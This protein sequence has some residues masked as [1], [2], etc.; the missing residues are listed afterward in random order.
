MMSLLLKDAI[1]ITGDEK[2]TVINEGYIGIKGSLIDYV[3]SKCEKID[4]RYDRILDL[5]NK[6]IMPGFVNAHNHSAMTIF[7]NYADDLALMDWLFNKIFPLEEKLTA[8][9]VYWASMLAVLEMIRTGTTAFCDM[10]MFME[11]TA[12]V[13]SESGIKAALGRGL[14]GDIGAKDSYRLKESIE[15]YKSYHHSNNGRIRVNLAPHSVY[16]CTLSYLEEIAKV[17]I[18]L[19]C[20]VQIH[21]SETDDEVSKSILEHK[22]TPVKVADEVGLLSN[23]TIA[24]HCVAVNDDD[25]EILMKKKVNVVHNPS[26]NMKLGSGIAPIKGMLDKGIN[27]AIGTDGASSNNGLDMLREMRNASYLQKVLL[28]D[29]T[30][31]NVDQAIKMS[32]SN[33]A[34]ALGFKNT[35]KIA[36]GNAA[37]IIIINTDKP[38][39]YPKHNVKSSIVYSG[40]SK[41]V[42]TV[43]VDGNIIMENGQIVTID[44]ERVMYEVQRAAESLSY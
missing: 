16:T 23:K 18:D 28:K 22:M 42:E 31:I 25:I 27:I 8:K 21:L 32:T 20:E 1:I 43:I 30:A 19:N 24:A 29:P 6:V 13:V 4:S 14:Q 41:D 9:D 11:E 33:G 44:E 40:N 2:G 39:Y 35:G 37:D 3:G 7:R 36:E 34:K 38:W 5:K 26:S 17:A 12:R 15:L 10:Y